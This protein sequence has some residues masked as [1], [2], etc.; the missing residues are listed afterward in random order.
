MVIIGG[1]VVTDVILVFLYFL[2]P[3]DIC[4]LFHSL[5]AVVRC[6]NSKES[7][8]CIFRLLN[9]SLHVTVKDLRKLCIASIYPVAI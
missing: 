9:L 3:R 7:Y 6:L 2:L 4:F 8:A 5:S 1:N